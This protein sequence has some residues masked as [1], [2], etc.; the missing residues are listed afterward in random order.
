MS[1]VLSEDAALKTMLQGITVSDDNNSSRP[2][3]VWYGYPDIE[4]RD[5]NFPFITIDL[6][7]IIAGNDRQ[8]WGYL[9]DTD[10]LGTQATVTDSSYVYHVPAAYDIIYQVT[11][12]SRHPRHDRAII[13]QLFNLFPSKY[14]YLNVP[15]DTNAYGTSRSMFLDGFVKRDAVEGETGN[16]RLLRNVYTLR[17]LSQMTPAT[18]MT[19]LK[20]VSTVK[21][22]TNT[23]Y[24]PSGYYPV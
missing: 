19:A 12:Y 3:R 22:N 23:S 20:N 1:F 18:A 7:D 15:V 11:T 6:I 17:V 10:A 5:Q 13:Q 16:R 8:T 21:L 4:I 14:A 9:K 24:I 2:V